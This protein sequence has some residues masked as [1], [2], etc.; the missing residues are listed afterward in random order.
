MDKRVVEN[1]IRSVEEHIWLKRDDEQFCIQSTYAYPRRSVTHV[2]FQWNTHSQFVQ[3]Q[4]AGNEMYSTHRASLSM[5]PMHGRSDAVKVTKITVEN[6]EEQIS[7]C[8]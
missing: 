7:S 8:S 2:K 1:A 4:T 3:Y 5:D 6:R